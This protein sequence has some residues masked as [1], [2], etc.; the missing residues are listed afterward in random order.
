MTDAQLDI[1]D[2]FDK[3]IEAHKAGKAQ[4]AD[5]Y[6]T[7]VLKAQPNHPDA[8]HNMGVLAVGIGKV[9]EALPF[10]KKAIEANPNIPQFWL[11]LVDA[12]VKLNQTDA[13]NKVVSKLQNQS[14]PSTELDTLISKLQRMIKPPDQV[15]NAREQYLQELNSLI[16]L[17]KLILFNSLV[18]I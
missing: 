6:Y 10:F 12:L 2:A 1:K 18:K 17:Y 11:S 13:A 7:A 8:N 15:S 5:R 4:E 9:Q 16:K 14:D 3:A